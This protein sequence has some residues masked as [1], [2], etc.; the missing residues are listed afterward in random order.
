MMSLSMAGRIGRLRYL[1]FSWPI[2]ALGSLLAMM[3]AVVVPQHKASG[4]ILLILAAVLCLWMPLRLMAMRFHDVNL[5]AKWV[6]ALL[7]FPGLAGAVGASHMVV[8]CAGFFWV[9][10]I[11]LVA[12]PGS[13]SENDFGPPPGDNTTAVKVGA[14]VVLFLM[15]LGVIGNIRLMNSGKLNSVLSRDQR[16]AAEAQQSAPLT[17][18][19][20]V[21]TWEGRNM[22]LRVD[23][24]GYGDFFHFDGRYSI[25]A[26]GPLRVLD[27]NRISIGFGP[28]PHL[29]N[30]T[31]P[32]HVESNVAKMTIDGVEMVGTS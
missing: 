2:F 16:T 29:L 17:K 30:V 31:V 1:A 24:N 3:A 12:L 20:F 8:I 15:A 13:E 7:L 23:Q 21:G 28:D 4:M 25:R 19:A 22:S 5:S 6:L 32:P 18:S 26:T 10:A 11:V 14:G 27:D 9:A